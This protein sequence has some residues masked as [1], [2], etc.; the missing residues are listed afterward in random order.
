LRRERERE[1]KEC[2]RAF[3]LIEIL[4]VIAIVAVIS[5]VAFL[6]LPSY[7]NI[8]DLKN[9]SQQI[10]ALLREAQARSVNG[11]GGASWG[12]HFENS[13]TPFYALFSGSSYS[14]T[15]AVG[16]YPLLSD[17]CYG[18]IG[19]GSSQD[20]TF[21]Q[22]SGSTS[23][24]EI[25]LFEA[26]GSCTN[27]LIWSATT[28]L[29]VPIVQLAA[30]SSGNAVYT[31]GGSTNGNYTGIT[32][33]VQYAA[34]N[35][36]G[37]LGAW[38]GTTPFPSGIM[39]GPSEAATYNGYIYV[40][41]GCSG[42]CPGTTAS[43]TV[44]YAP[45]NSDHTIGSWL[46]ATS[47]PNTVVDN[48]TLAQGGALYSFGGVDRYAA[49]TSGVW[50]AVINTDGS[51]GSWQA[52]TPLPQA[53]DVS[54]P[55]YADGYVYLLGYPQG[56]LAGAT[57][58]LPIWYA[59][60]NPDHTVGQWQNGTVVPSYLQGPALA[61]SNGD[62]YVVGGYSITDSTTTSAVWMA[63]LSSDHTVGQWLA[64][65]PMP[66]ALDDLPA[67]I[68]G[69]FLYIV[70]G[71]NGVT[72]ATSTVSYATTQ[73]LGNVSIEASSTITVNQQGLVSF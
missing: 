19:V 29:P 40:V 25:D 37:S 44:M 49:V 35:G 42:D 27:K 28:Q 53:L 33:T 57:G 7:R 5:T 32:S 65:T 11:S 63:P 46:Q 6:N 20:V 56:A 9:T 14:S 23:A 3:S 61:Y 70:G 68:N 10:V 71:W 72:H 26:S 34:I 66:G 55:V 48:A 69:G 51:L 73:N 54:G 45:I 59:P 41:G 60:L 38:Q 62:L 36:D 2:Q 17:L 64:T 1:S 58:T 43:T 67:I 15:S 18:N 22:V 39:L 8:A 13:A 52:T 47:F 24:A 50:Y 21:A 4:V 16:H 12:V 31:I 30:V